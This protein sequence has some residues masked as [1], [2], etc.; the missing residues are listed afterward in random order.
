M[1]EPIHA[2]RDK[3]SAESAVE[4]AVERGVERGVESRVE[5]GVE[6]RADAHLPNTAP[7]LTPLQ[8]LERSRERLRLVL[9]P[10]PRPAAD[11]SAS[12]SGKSWEQRLRDIPGLAVAIDVVKVWWQQHPLHAASIVAAEVGRATLRP[13]AN[14][15]P[16]ALVALAMVAGAV[17]AWARPWRWALR[18]ALFAG[19]LPQ[20]TSRV[21]AS[22]PIEAW[23]KVLGTF[24]NGSNRSAAP[25]PPTPPA[26]P[27]PPT[28]SDPT[29]AAG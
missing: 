16:M 18:S 19:L 17:L 9:A 11:A 29:R 24:M 4:R 1:S 20:V 22:L 3:S 15:H 23:L 12:G 10:P 7:A 13:A 14:R 6:S 26:P 27:A 21:V 8:R 5:S 28:D 2:G 25:S